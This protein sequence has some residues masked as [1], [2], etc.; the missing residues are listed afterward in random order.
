M[1]R[2]VAGDRKPRT[3]DEWLHCSSMPSNPPSTQWVATAAYPATIS[4]ISAVL[5]ALG[6]SRNSGSATADGAH[7][8]RREY[9]EDAWPPLWLIWAKIGTRWRCTASVIRR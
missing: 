9:I 3:I 7:T 4:P 1:R 5:T 6:T 8:A 2:L